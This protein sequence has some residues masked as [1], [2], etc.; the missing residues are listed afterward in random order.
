M[1]V[2]ITGQLHRGENG[3]TCS[4]RCKITKKRQCLSEDQGMFTFLVDELW[5][6]LWLTHTKSSLLH[7]QRMNRA[8]PLT[9]CQVFNPK[10]L[11]WQIPTSST[12][13]RPAVVTGDLLTRSREEA[14]SHRTESKRR[15]K[16]YQPA[17]ASCTLSR[18]E[19]H[20]LLMPSMMRL[21]SADPHT[22]HWWPQLPQVFLTPLLRIQVPKNFL[23]DGLY[24]T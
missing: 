18:R 14:V 13:I 3:G 4:R 20:P 1:P 6:D 21:Q 17:R 19:F 7:H 10:I 5:L 11:Q 9:P 2:R 24:Q 8:L 23:W 22:L 12:V 15:R 16:L